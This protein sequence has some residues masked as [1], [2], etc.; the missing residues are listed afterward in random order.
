[1]SRLRQILSAGPQTSWP[2]SSADDW[3]AQLFQYLKELRRTW[4]IMQILIGA[5]LLPRG[6]TAACAVL[7]VCCLVRRR[8]VLAM[9]FSSAD[10]PGG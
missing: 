4:Y 3:P 10:D 9:S 2:R 1:M 5:P 7:S 6:M 8:T